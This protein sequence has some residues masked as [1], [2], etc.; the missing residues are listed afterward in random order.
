MVFVTHSI[1]EAAFLSTRVLVMS[2]RPGRIA[3]ELVIDEP[4]PRS[5]SFRGSTRFAY[6]CRH[7]SALLADAEA[8]GAA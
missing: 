7:L 6:H 3:S 5:E 8:A 1:Y 4:Q 2:A